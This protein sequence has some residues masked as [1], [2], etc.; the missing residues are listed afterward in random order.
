MFWTRLIRWLR[1]T[2]TNKVNFYI[3]KNCDEKDLSTILGLGGIGF[4]QDDFYDDDLAHVLTTT[5]NTV[6][7]RV[8]NDVYIVPATIKAIVNNND[9]KMNLWFDY[10]VEMKRKDLV[11]CS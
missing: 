3:H 10:P 4:Q 6:C 11:K 5:N 8:G 2:E 1:D 7:Y 9:G